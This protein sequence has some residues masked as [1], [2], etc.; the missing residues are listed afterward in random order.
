MQHIVNK[1]ACL[2][3][4]LSKAAI[5]SCCFSNAELVFCFI[6]LVRES[7][8][9]HKRDFRHVGDLQH[10]EIKYTLLWWQYSAVSMYGFVQKLAFVKNL[11]TADTTDYLLWESRSLLLLLISLGGIKIFLGILSSEVSFHPCW[12]LRWKSVGKTSCMVVSLNIS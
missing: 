5:I 11:F 2:S 8:L 6:S 7:N 1:I 9:C 4:K 10:Y 12:M 3:E